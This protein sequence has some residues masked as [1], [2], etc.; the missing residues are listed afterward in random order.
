MPTHTKQFTYQAVYFFQFL[1]PANEKTFLVFHAVPLP[2]ITS[3]FYQYSLLYRLPLMSVQGQI[4]QD[5]QAILSQHLKQRR[6]SEL[7]VYVESI[8]F[9]TTLYILTHAVT[10]TTPVIRVQF[11]LFIQ[12]HAKNKTHYF[13]HGSLHT[14]LY[15]QEEQGDSPLRVIRLFLT[16][17]ITLSPEISIPSAQSPTK[18]WSIERL[19]LYSVHG[20]DIWSK[21]RPRKGNTG[22]SIVRCATSA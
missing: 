6:L 18:I 14:L 9:T 4:G 12:R 1:L 3:L 20:T 19:L 8:T 17:E 2:T 10:Q 16:A 7:L 13:E 5:D 22:C 11:T 21:E 15:N